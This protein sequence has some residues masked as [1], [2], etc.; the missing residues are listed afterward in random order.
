MRAVD[1]GYFERYYTKLVRWVSQ[2]RLLRDSNRGVLLVDKERALLG[3]QVAVRAHL[4]DP[5]FNPLTLEEV[6]AVLVQPDNVRK[7][8]VLRK[9]KDAAREGMYAGLV[10]TSMEGD[11]RLELPVPQS[12]DDELL[13]REIRVRVPDR[14]IEHPQRNDA[15]LKTIADRTKGE[16][17]VGLNA[18]LGRGP[19]ARPPLATVITPRDQETF[20]SGSR[21]QTFER[22]LAGWLMTLVCGVLFLEWTIRRLHKLA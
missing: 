19:E 15:L 10:T 17:Y 18:A 22:L 16:Y 3:D 20:L 5:Q 9:I 1:V 7:P 21:D 4:T 14:E 13:T 6:Q 8:L 2:G 11:Y 12:P